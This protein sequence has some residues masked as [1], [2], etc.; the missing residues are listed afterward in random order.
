MEHPVIRS[1]KNRFAFVY[2]LRHICHRIRKG[3]R[4]QISPRFSGDSPKSTWFSCF[5]RSKY[6][7]CRDNITSSVCIRSRVSFCE[8]A[9]NWDDLL[10]ENR[11][12]ML[13]AIVC[14]FSS[15]CSWANM[16]HKYLPES[17][18][19]TSWLLLYPFVRQH[20]NIIINL[21]VCCWLSSKSANRLC[22]NDS[23]KLT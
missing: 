15:A 6:S 1:A 3:Q 14:H 13:F 5:I 18:R 20:E 10:L 22:T 2:G 4:R 9:T 8:A 11:S 12:A 19:I 23:F 7:F 16:F 17:W 21:C